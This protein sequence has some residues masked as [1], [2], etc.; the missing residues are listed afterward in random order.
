MAARDGEAVPA[1]GPQDASGVAVLRVA[2]VGRRYHRAVAVAVGDYVVL[3]PEPTNPRDPHAVVVSRCAPEAE[4]GAE[5]AALGHLPAVVARVVGPVLNEHG[6]VGLVARGRVVEAKADAVTVEVA[7]G[8]E[9]APAAARVAWAEAVAAVGAEGS[10]AGPNRSYA[11]SARF[12]VET[13]LARDARVWV[14]AERAVLS[15]FLAAGEA[16]QSLYARLMQ[17]KGSWFRTEGMRYAEVPEVLDAAEVLHHIGLVDWEDAV[18]RE[19]DIGFGPAID[20]SESARDVP[21]ASVH[22]DS[23]A[24]GGAAEA[25]M[26]VLFERLQ[27]LTMPELRALAAK[28]NLPGVGGGKASAAGPVDKDS[29]V[30]AFR[31]HVR[32]Q[33]DLFGNHSLGGAGTPGPAAATGIADPLLEDLAAR[34]PWRPAYSGLCV[35]LSRLLREQLGGR[36]G[37]VGI[38]RPA[39]A[40]FR[41]CFLLFFLDASMDLSSFVLADIGQNVYPCSRLLLDRAVAGDSV[42]APAD[43]VFRSRAQ[44]LAYEAACRLEHATE[45]A[46]EATAAADGR[47]DDDATSAAAEALDQCVAVVEGVLGG[48]IDEVR[49]L[50][51]WPPFHRRFSPLWRVAVAGG[52]AV[53]G[54]ERAKRHADAVRVLRLLLGLPLLCPSRRGGWW[55]RLLIDAN[56]AGEAPLAIQA[57]AETALGDPAVRGGDAVSLRHRHATLSWQQQAG[58]EEKAPK[59]R[60]RGEGGGGEEDPPAAKGRARNRGKAPSQ[61]LPEA[62]REVTI[63]GRPF[64]RGV[65]SK[66]LYF[67]HTDGS[68]VSVEELV[69]GHYADAAHGEWLGAHSEGGIWMALFVLF[70]WDVVYDADVPGVFVHP[71]QIRPLDLGTDAFF[72]T[73]RGSIEAI[74]AELR[75]SMPAEVAARCLKQWDA[76]E[77]TLCIGLGRWDRWERREVA[78]IAAAAGGRCLAAIFRTLCEDFAHWHGGLPDLVLWKPAYVADNPALPQGG[79]IRLV[80]VKGPSDSLMDR[81][82]AWLEILSSVTDVEVCYVRHSVHGE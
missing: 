36:R 37:S 56:H 24:S 11:A 40:L 2:V 80:E 63:Q 73:R 30:R 65:G 22:P 25:A 27:L 38:S 51:A 21:A 72:E 42:P 1:E 70:M 43:P 64:R 59:R 8:V 28:F 67:N 5:S 20:A 26:D 66:N 33:R 12:V 69:L 71:F 76:H 78:E 47:D 62:V 48:A 35:T 61:G 9:N 75:G 60:R 53:A 54:L 32:V 34:R 57:L 31:R 82:R 44:L 10:V 39:A 4:A 41:R 81:Q 74:L 52:R 13:V 6:R 79:L 3:R 68:A 49:G 45:A 14:P 77:G 55:I 50:E 18:W 17:R 16:A 15:G 46:C 19:E 29:I 58:G 7:G 23:A